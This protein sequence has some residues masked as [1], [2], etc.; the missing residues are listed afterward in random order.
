MYLLLS[1][2]RRG[3][4]SGHMETTEAMGYRLNVLTCSP[5]EGGGKGYH[6]FL[7]W[8]SP[9]C[10][11]STVE[12]WECRECDCELQTKG[13]WGRNHYA[14]CRSEDFPASQV[15]VRGSGQTCENHS[16]Q[17]AVQWVYVDLSREWHNDFTIMPRVVRG[18]DKKMKHFT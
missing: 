18:K 12:T 1:D 11:C 9:E 5:D 8:L 7:D 17:L 6:L 14:S 16:H 3:S 4:D 15:G 10:Y 2:H 13:R